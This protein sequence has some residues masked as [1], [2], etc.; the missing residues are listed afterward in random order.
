[1]R[2]TAGCEEENDWGIN[3]SRRR[4]SQL[5]PLKWKGWMVISQTLQAYVY[6][7]IHLLETLPSIF[8]N[9]AGGMLLR[10]LMPFTLSFWPFF[11]A[12]CLLSQLLLSCKGEIQRSCSW[13]VAEKVGEQCQVACH[14]RRYPPLP[15]P[16]PPPPPPRLLGTTVA[17][18]MVP[19]LRPWWTEVDVIVLGTVSCASVV[20]LLSAIIICYKAIKR[21]PLRKEENGTSRGEYAMS[22][23]NKKAMGTN[24]TVV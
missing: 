2:S 15:P 17:Q 16:P 10:D 6:S 24:N 20:F 18:P 11:I 22:I 14:C 4:L 12:H 23:R 19:L 9:S 13:T 7:C 8:E 3:Y 5:Q 1:M 21:K